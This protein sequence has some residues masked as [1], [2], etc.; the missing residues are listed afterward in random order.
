M[1]PFAED[2]DVCPEQYLEFEEADEYREKWNEGKTSL[3]DLGP[4]DPV[5]QRLTERSERFVVD[6]QMY[7]WP[8]DDMF[9]VSGT[10][11]IGAGTHKIPEQLKKVD[12]PYNKLY[13][14]FDVFMQDYAGYEEKDQKTGRYGRWRNPNAKWDWYKIGGRWRGYFP[15]KADVRPLVGEP[16]AFDNPSQGGSDIVKVSNLDMD[17]IALK[18]A[19]A[20]YDFEKEY[21]QLLKGATFPP[22]DGPCDMM[23][24]LNLLRIEKDPNAA[25]GPDEVVIAA[26]WSDSDEKRSKWREVAKLVS[27]EEFENFRPVFNPI[28]P[29]AA[30]DDRGWHSAENMGWFG[31][32]SPSGS[33]SLLEWSVRFQRE[34]IRDSGP[35]DLLVLVD[36]HI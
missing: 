12:I 29:F 23:N 34:F 14:S 7:V 8:F 6:G 3:V 18:E 1:V 2:A 28:R 17:A 30:L 31:C 24:R 13:A 32:S 27:E 10:I 33:V 15:V 19:T 5:L 35:D 4:D 25:I 21:K 16:G 22:F 11:G 36:C 9:R 20:F 26:A